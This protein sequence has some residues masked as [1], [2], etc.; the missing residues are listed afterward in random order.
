[1]PTTKIGG[2][3]MTKKSKQLSGSA[4][5]GVL[6]IWGTLSSLIGYFLLPI[7]DPTAS[8]LTI[9]AII[10]FVGTVAV[11]LETTKYRI[12]NWFTKEEPEEPEAEGTTKN[13]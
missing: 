4:F 3:K 9:P 2:N 10:T 12:G 13:G 5:V 8:P 11:I 6:L 1:M 7:L